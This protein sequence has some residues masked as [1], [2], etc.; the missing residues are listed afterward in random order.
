MPDKA[1]AF[2]HE[3]SGET[4]AESPVEMG[5]ID[6]RQNGKL[7]IVSDFHMGSGRN[8]D[9]D[10]NGPLVSAILRRYYYE[11][12][13]T[14]VL[15]GDIEELL[16]RGL[17]SIRKKWRELY[18]VFD[19]FHIK[20][21]LFKVLGNHDAALNHEKSYPYRLYETVRAVTASCC[22]YI[23]HGHQGSRIY[24]KYAGL[25]AAFV[26]YVLKPLGIG[27]ITSERSPQKRFAAEKRAYDFSLAN[28]VFSII[29]HT[30]RPLFESL[31]RFEYIKYE[32]ERLCR[33]YPLVKGD[34]ERERMKNEVAALRDELAKLGKKERRG[35]L[36]PSLYGG[37]IPVPCLFNAGSVI[38]KKG[39]TAIE[40]DNDSIS[41][42]YWWEEGKG[43]KFVQRG[44]Y[45]FEELYDCVSCSGL[46]QRKAVLNTE[47]LEYIKARMELLR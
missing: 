39:V 22:V 47:K 2:F 40:L 18:T 41:L 17:V 9:L 30:H 45:L 37:E 3:L 29:G 32:I 8:D 13:W 36:R 19:L 12:G 28:G 5:E 26:R 6:L 43:K 15:N 31:G 23:Y 27:N 35:I 33:E 46:V 21:R 42:V 24:R 34:I 14:L 10:R 4:D 16:K 1:A 11:R 25:I 20:G 38:G 44:G 7:L